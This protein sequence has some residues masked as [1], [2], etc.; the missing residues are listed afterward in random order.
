MSYLFKG[1]MKF[2]CHFLR[3]NISMKKL[4][5]IFSFLLY[6]S[7]FQTIYARTPAAP[8]V[9]FSSEVVIQGEPIMVKIEGISSLNE[10]KR[11][12]FAG[13][14]WKPIMID[15][16]I[17]GLLGTDIHLK[18]AKY[19]LILEFS[20][21]I[22]FVKEI[23][24]LK[25]P[26]IEEPLGIPDKL[27]GNTTQSQNN[28]VNN[29]AKENA[30]L[31]NIKTANAAVWWE[32][33]VMPLSYVFVTSPFGYDRETGTYTIAHKGTD[34]RANVGTEV[35]AINRGIVRVI[36]DGQTYGKTL[37]IDHGAGLQSFY[38][39]LSQINVKV[40]EVVSRGQIVALS[41]ESGYTLGPHLHLSI[42][43]NGASI[44]PMKFF[45]LFNNFVK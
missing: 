8:V 15:E 44:D 36:G 18:P 7:T 6:L 35:L 23:T 13:K 26:K 4:L 5:F 37:V 2:F 1:K 20:N 45:E 25:R 17:Y 43:I 28:L 29:L 9:T 27:G 30:A 16:K 33:F 11:S 22:L 41:G 10:I 40:G 34:F 12:E 21:G 3:Y 24:V 14:Y 39:H 42:R 32:N 19:K 38:L 31:E